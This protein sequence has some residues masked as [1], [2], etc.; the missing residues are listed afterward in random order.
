MTSV[1]PFKSWLEINLV[2]DLAWKLEEI[3]VH[4][5]R[6]ILWQAGFSRAKVNTFSFFYWI[7]INLPHLTQRWSNNLCACEI[8]F[9]GIEWF[10]KSKSLDKDLIE[11]ADLDRDFVTS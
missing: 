10:M 11:V 4:D 7:I 9:D 2:I 8:F 1:N 6:F 5:L 3:E